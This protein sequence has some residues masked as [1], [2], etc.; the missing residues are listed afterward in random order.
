[1]KVVLYVLLNALPLNSLDCPVYQASSCTKTRGSA[2]SL[3]CEKNFYNF[4]SADVFVGFRRICNEDRSPGW[5]RRPL[6][7]LEEAFGSY[8]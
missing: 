3:S 8:L 2:N 1:M 4:Y 5:S 6:G 7:R